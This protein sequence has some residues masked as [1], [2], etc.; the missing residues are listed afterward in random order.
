MAFSDGFFILKQHSEMTWTKKSQEKEK[1][2]AGQ[3]LI[4]MYSW[5]NN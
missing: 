5:Q 3:V 2:D 1:Q 4:F